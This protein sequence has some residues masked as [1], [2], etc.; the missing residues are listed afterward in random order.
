MKY[1]LV[2]DDDL[3]K[4]VGHRVEV[5]GKAADRGRR[6][7]EDRIERSTQRQR[8]DATTKTEIKGRT[9]RDELPRREIGEDDFDVLHVGSLVRRAPARLIP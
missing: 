6:Q 5:N 2:T 4:H 3:S 7:S 8:Q 9:S 1:A